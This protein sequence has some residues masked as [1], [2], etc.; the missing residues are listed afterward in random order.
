[1]AGGEKWTMEKVCGAQQV[2]LAFFHQ[3]NVTFRTGSKVTC[4]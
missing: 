3:E 1:M 4:R 2:L